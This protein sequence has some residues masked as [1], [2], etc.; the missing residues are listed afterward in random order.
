MAHDRAITAAERDAA[1]LAPVLAI[2]NDIDLLESAIQRT[3]TGAD[4]RLTVW[5][6]PGVQVG[7][8]SPVR[9]EAVALVRSDQASFSQSTTD[10]LELYT[11]VV[12]GTADVVVIRARVPEAILNA[13]V[14][15]TWTAL[16]AVAFVLVLASAIMADRLARRLTSDAQ[17]LAGTARTLAAGNGA[18]RAAGSTTPE[19]DDAGRALNLLA[20]RIEELRAAER[21]RVAD[22]SH[23]LRT[24]LTGLRLEAEHEGNQQ[25]LEGVDRL[26]AAITE[27]INSA[28]RPLH[29]EAVRTTCDAGE[30]MLERTAFWSAL[31]EE[32]GRSWTVEVP[33]EPSIVFCTAADLGAAIDALVANIFSHTAPGTDYAVSA[34][35]DN[36]SVVIRVDD[37]GPGVDDDRL[38]DRGTTGAQST[39]LGLSIVDATAHAAGGTMK[40]SA[41][42]QGTRVELRLPLGDDT[43]SSRPSDDI[44]PQQTG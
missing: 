4:G 33:P 35:R 19:L 41:L 25:L 37:A 39:G 31:A 1:A 30:V 15:R 29:D 8:P 32:D 12:T 9:A 2:T 5:P 20:E 11:A 14:R 24:P 26:E 21:E 13:G 27:L 34:V 43:S 40:L 17:D 7:D 18:A 6:R 44:S 28:R 10:G 36:D 42:P 38:V 23:R 3:D 16:A 22:L